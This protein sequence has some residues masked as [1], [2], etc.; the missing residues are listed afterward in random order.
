MACPGTVIAKTGGSIRTLSFA[1]LKSLGPKIPDDHVFA[2]NKPAITFEADPVQE[3]DTYLY[4][5]RLGRT[6]D[7]A[8]FSD[9]PAEY[10]IAA[11]LEPLSE[12][13]YYYRLYAWD[14]ISSFESQARSF[15]IDTSPKVL[16]MS[17]EKPLSSSWFK[18]GSTVVF[19]ASVAGTT[20]EI[21]DETEAAA[22]IN[23]KAA[24][25]SLYFDKSRNKV[26]GI[27]Y[28][29]Q[30]VT[31]KENE[32]EVRLPLPDGTYA[33]ASAKLNVDLVGPGLLFPSKEPV[34]YSGSGKR[35]LIELSDDGSGPDNRNSSVK[36]FRDA[37]TIEGS[38]SAGPGEK[39][40]V[41]E[42]R[43]ALSDGI[44]KLEA[45][46]RDLAGNT[47]K[48]ATAV[49]IV[50]TVVPVITL[51]ETLPGELNRS[52]LAVTGKVD[53]PSVKKIFAS[54]N[55]KQSKEQL[56]SCDGTFCL[57]IGLEKGE[58]KV[59]ISAKDPAQNTATVSG[60]IIC[61]VMSSSAIFEFDGKQIA[62]GDYV[63]A[64]PSSVKITDSSG[65]PFAFAS[66]KLDSTSIAYDTSTG[67][68]SVG[69]LSA[70]KHELELETP[71]HTCSI[72]FFA[73][74]S[75]C[76]TDLLLCPNPFDPSLGPSKITY[77]L[78][79]PAQVKLYIFDQTGRL[80][81]SLSVPG[82]AGYNN[83]LEWDGKL[84]SGENASNGIYLI[85][86]LAQ[87]NGQATASAKGR[88]IVL[89]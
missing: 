16:S 73:E 44:Y 39:E 74:G 22:Y 45:V 55:G 79:R 19:E 1:R 77:N 17:V 68:A 34:L 42:P 89:R 38:C 25:S 14:G 29:P 62:E 5:V 6:S 4:S 30:E 32:L 28:L 46:I 9:I 69:T 67:S 61:T 76:L 11:F 57:G 3:A 72:E 27:I 56:V 18:K 12:G 47:A 64:S 49:L 52:S 50:D 31:Q 33:K 85:K 70:G 60:T 7:F 8:S 36:L 24:E 80:I 87:E 86:V 21:E 54:I 83:N 51:D 15:N 58:N 78:S 23:G 59:V 63:S 81:T 20:L 88:I 53:K 43:T 48:P 82:T 66:A 37:S 2:L 35:I 26:L 84:A 10:P 75:L 65:A 41:F 13:K 71:S 40:L